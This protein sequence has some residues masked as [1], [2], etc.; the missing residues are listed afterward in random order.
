MAVTIGLSLK[1]VATI[2]KTAPSALE[3]VISALG[4]VFRSVETGLHKI[5]RFPGC[6]WV[7]RGMGR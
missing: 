5:W 4:A 2:L 3:T 6:A 1:T 7:P